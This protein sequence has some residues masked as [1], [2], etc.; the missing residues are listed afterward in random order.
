[1]LGAALGRY[2][3]AGGRAVVTIRNVKDGYF[4]EALANG[5]DGIV[6][7]HRPEQVGHA[8]IAGELVF[9]LV[10]LNPLQDGGGNAL[11]L[12]V[13]QE[14]GLRL[15][16]AG[17]EVVDAVQLLLLAGQLVL[18]D[19]AVQVFIHAGAA[20]DAGLHASPHHL[21]VNV[22]A[23]FGFALQ[24]PLLKEFLEV[25]AALLVCFG[26]VD[27]G[28]AGVDIGAADVQ[29]GGRIAGSHGTGFSMVHHIIRQAGDLLGVFLGGADCSKGTY[30]CHKLFSYRLKGNQGLPSC[31]KRTKTAGR[32]REP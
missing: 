17:I 31:T 32:L 21:A 8:V 19:G 7:R 11:V 25:L 16:G 27:S 29:V 5:C 4:L 30:C 12:A 24:E 13:G 22:I 1:M 15:G 26:V 6:I 9:R 20:D 3:G 18:L 2:G 23:G 14:D 10:E 28:L